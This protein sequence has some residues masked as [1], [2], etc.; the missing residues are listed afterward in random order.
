[1]ISRFT[2]FLR[3]PSRSRGG[4]D[5]SLVKRERALSY[6]AADLQT[7]YSHVSHSSE[8]PEAKGNDNTNLRLTAEAEQRQRPPPGEVNTQSETLAA[9]LDPRALDLRQQEEKEFIRKHDS[10]AAGLWYLVDVNW[11]HEWRLFVTRRGALPGPIDNGRL[12]EGVGLEP[13]HDY[14]GVN[15]EIWNFWYQRYGGGPVVRRR[16]LD[17]YSEPADEDWDEAPSSCGSARKNSALDTNGGW[18]RNRLSSPATHAVVATHA[19]AQSECSSGPRSP[20]SNGCSAASPRMAAAAPPSPPM[21]GRTVERSATALTGTGRRAGGNARGSA[22]SMSTRG[23]S[24]P[25]SRPTRRVEDDEGERRKVLC[26]DKC[27][28]PHD[29]SKCPHFKKPREKHADAWTGYGKS[30]SS[31]DVGDGAPIVRNA[32]VFQQPADGS[33]LF[34]SLSFGLSDRSTA[35]SLRRDICNYIAKNPDMTIADTALKEWIRYD[36]G[37]TVQSYADRMRGDTWGGG[38]EMA[39]L[40]KMKKVNVHV[41]EKCREG[42]VE[43]YRRISAFENPGALKTVSVLYQGRMHYDAIVV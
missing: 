7:D 5:G 10:D 35:P 34:H 24:A 41:Y 39:A 1:M 40:T 11:L 12:L 20:V 6:D 8:Q 17:L 38:I 14:R 26:C 15:S 31:K 22:S 16:Q 32:K 29:S 23:A 2:G 43:G 30:K 4:K 3:L 42:G 36:S 25:A 18:H 27:D 37:G 33:C 19:E 28:G 13:V 21:R 9:S